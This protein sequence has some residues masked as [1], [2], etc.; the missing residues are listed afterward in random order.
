MPAYRSPEEKLIRD[1]A[2]DRLRELL[3]SARIIHEIN[4]QSFGNR[5]DVLAVTEDRIV[6]VEV[7][8][9]KDTLKRLRDQIS[10]MNGVAH[11]V[12]TAMHEKFLTCNTQYNGRNIWNVPEESLGSMPWVFPKAERHGLL[13]EEYTNWNVKDRFKKNVSCLPPYALHMLWAD[14]LK[15][16]CKRNGLK[17]TGTMEIIRDRITWNLTGADVTKNICAQLRARK[18]VEADNEIALE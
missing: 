7:K 15:M 9:E 5:I 10:A 3:P 17:Q 8:S 2:I 16:I 12:I 1:A 13:A 18:C 14:E 6:A 11:H 4:A